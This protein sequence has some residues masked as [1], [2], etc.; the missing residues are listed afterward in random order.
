[1]IENLG[2]TEDQFDTLNLCDNEI[3]KLDNFPKMLRLK[4]LLVCNNRVARIDATVAESLVHLTSLILTNNHL[5]H[6]ADIDALEGC[7]ELRH[8]V[9][10]D[11]DIAKKKHY[12]AYV[13]HKLP[14]L[15]TLDF[16]KI[17]TKDRDAAKKQFA[18]KAGERLK[19]EIQ[20]ARTFVPG[21]GLA[22][23]NRLTEEQINEI[24]AAINKATTIEEVN[25][26]EKALKA[27]QY[28]MA[29]K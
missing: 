3:A 2:S 4:S 12:K 27:G 19:A 22:G 10:I 25:R 15:K 21:E 13:I 28:P 18:G 6:L 7:K 5:K 26:L 17:K 20:A 23:E 24:K 9:L 29:D 11:N 1:L 16:Q 8:L 14:Q